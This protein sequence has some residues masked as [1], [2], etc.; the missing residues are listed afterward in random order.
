MQ[1]ANQG[2]GCT[3]A[4][5]V[6]EATQLTIG[7]VCVVNTIARGIGQAC[8]AAICIIVIAEGGHDT[9]TAGTS[10]RDQ[11][12][13]GIVGVGRGAI[14]IN[15]AGEFADAIS[16]LIVVVCDIEAGIGVADVG[17]AVERIV[18]V[19]DGDTSCVGLGKPV[20][21]LIIGVGRGAGI[22]AGLADQVAQAIIIVSSGESV[23]IGN[24]GQVVLG[25]VGV[26]GR[27]I[28]GVGLLL[29]P[30]EGIVRLGSGIEFG[31]GGLCE[32]AVGVIAVRGIVILAVDQFLDLTQFV[33]DPL[34]VAG[35]G[36]VVI[37]DLLAQVVAHG[38]QSIVDAVALVV[39]HPDKSMGG[40]IVVADKTAI[41]LGNSGEV[42]DRIKV[43][44]R[45]TG[46]G[47][48]AQALLRHATPEVIVQG[49]GQAVR[50]DDSQWSARSIMGGNLGHLTQGIGDTD[51]VALGIVA[52]RGDIRHVDT[53]AVDGFDLALGGIGVAGGAIGEYCVEAEADAQAHQ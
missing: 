11:V 39:F 12:A 18:A 38:I 45:C 51:A 31:I 22:G 28:E 36:A 1:I 4:P 3:I 42:A 29:E 15:D 37:A 33:I 27:T 53:G 52:V 50:I 44:Q 34:L 24:A 30:V 46:S 23:G 10:L 14:G 5:F 20:A 2:L 48:I 16:T 7:I 17:Q 8:Q 25:I 40:I 9:V 43:I 47:A 35:Q 32:I 26:L 19:V 49:S 13:V 41:G 21:C 6:G